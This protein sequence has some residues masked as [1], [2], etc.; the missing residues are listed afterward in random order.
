M[1]H[2]FMLFERK[3]QPLAPESEFGRRQARNAVI[4]GLMIGASLGIGVVG[5]HVTGGH[6]WLDSLY[7]ASMILGGMG[8]VSSCIEDVEPAEK[9]FASVYALFAGVVFLVSVGVMLAPAIHRAI[10]HF[11]LDLDEDGGKP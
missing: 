3:T 9:W 1:I 6:G 7:N 10:H 5:Y 8:P 11:H 2:K 4:A